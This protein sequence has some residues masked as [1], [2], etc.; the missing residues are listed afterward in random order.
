MPLCG[1]CPVCG[2]GP[3]RPIFKEFVISIALPTQSQHMVGTLRAYECEEQ[4]H[5]FFVMVKDIEGTDQREAQ[6]QRSSVANSGTS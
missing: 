1:N 3:L 5:I 2:K 6:I 4:R